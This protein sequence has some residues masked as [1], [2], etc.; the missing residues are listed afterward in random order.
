MIIE[1]I[2]ITLKLSIMVII[3]PTLIQ[4]FFSSCSKN[5]EFYL[6]KEDIVITGS[7]VTN[8]YTTIYMVRIEHEALPL[9]CPKINES[10]LTKA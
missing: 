3:P 7:F 4:Y 8:A 1:V 10:V 2:L 6:R 9:E 5:Q